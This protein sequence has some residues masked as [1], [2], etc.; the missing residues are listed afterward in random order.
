MEV[1]VPFILDIAFLM[2]KSPDG[3]SSKF[4]FIFRQK[5]GSQEKQAVNVCETLAP[6]V[7]WLKKL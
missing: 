2:L 3:Q 5:V 4:Y 1:T 7:T 6:G